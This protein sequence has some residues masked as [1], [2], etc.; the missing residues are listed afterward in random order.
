MWSRQQR[1]LLLKI[2]S[3]FSVVRGYNIPVIV[4]AQYLAAIFILAPEGQRALHVILDPA[5]FLLVLC[6]SMA[7]ASGYIINNFYDLKKDLINRP[8][9]FSFDK[10]VSQE[11]QF[12]IYFVL[13][14]LVL[15][16]SWFISFR[17][18][19]FFAAYMFLL[20]LYSHKIKKYPIVGNLT[21]VLLAIL[22]F[23]ALL[24]YYKNLQ[25][26]IIAHGVFLYLLLLI[27][28]MLKDLENLPGDL[29]A[30]YQT[31][32]VRFGEKPAKLLICGLMVSCLM[33]VY[34]LVEF[35]QVGYMESYLYASLMGLCLVGLLLW[36]AQSRKQYV[37]LHIILKLILIAGVCSIVLIHPQVLVHGKKV[38]QQIEDKAF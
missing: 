10:W 33:P 31:F 38:V 14:G 19:L 20:W 2:L 1:L 9:K 23:F 28:E 24:L 16:V 27:R 11:T 13:N 37:R 29:V 34:Y 4:L 17:A 5:L 18:M 25:W 26:Q 35:G 21:A 12:K 22:P 6:S 32:P 8:Y 15:L 7:I 36:S 3:L 30:Q